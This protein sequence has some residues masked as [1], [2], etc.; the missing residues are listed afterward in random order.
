MSIKNNYL[1]QHHRLFRDTVRDFVKTELLPNIHH[2]EEQGFVPKS[3]FQQM[4]DL[5]FL[6]LE[7]DNKFGG[8]QTDFW[9][10]VVFAEE[11][12]KCKSGGVGFSIIVHTDMSSP[13]L[14]KYGN[15]RQKSE[16]MADIVKGKQICA[17]AITEPDAGSD[18][19][20]ISTTAI[21]KDGNWAINGTKTF[22][23]NGVYGDLF[24]LAAK[25]N[26]S[27]KYHQ[28]L[29][30]FIVPASTPGITVTKKLDKTGMRSSD[31]AELVFEN[32]KV[33]ES[34]LLGV[35]NEGFYQ[36]ASGL[37]RERL[38][39]SVMSI[40]A[41]EDTLSD[42]IRY[43]SSRRTFGKLLKSHQVIRHKVAELATE[44]ESAKALNYMAADLYSKGIDCSKEVSMAKLHTMS[45]VNKIAYET[46]QMHG[47][48]GYIRELSAERFARDYRLWAIAGGTNEMMKEIIS[49]NMLG[50]VES[51]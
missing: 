17:L 51:D 21:K 31:T 32:V 34:N 39:A 43:L 1:Q 23:T 47:G 37:Q 44:I 15:E 40:S 6:G 22:I 46:V 8:A 26:N 11:L 19:A 45:V 18:M 30:Q 24:F 29:S 27:S 49:K 42:T 25:T 35:E 7:F 3:V 48:Y 10:T 2:W 4:G 41:A 16:F 20:G 33:S 38:L 9:M 5:G 14:H 50:K 36:L 12:A 13:W 28:N